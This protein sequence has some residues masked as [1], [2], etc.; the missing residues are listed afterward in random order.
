MARAAEQALATLEPSSS[1]AFVN[2]WS[3]YL[4]SIE[5]LTAKIAALKAADAGHLLPLPSLSP[6]ISPRR[7]GCGS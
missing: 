2:N 3:T 7:S 6:A 5:P 1:A 4:A